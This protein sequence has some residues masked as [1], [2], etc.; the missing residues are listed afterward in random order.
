MI[1]IAQ[2]GEGNFLRAF[3]DLY[4]QT[5]NDEGGDYVV[6]VIKPT[7]RPLGAGF[8]SEGNSYNVVLRGIADGKECE[9]TYKVNCLDKVIL[10]HAEAERFYALAREPELKVIVSNTT[11]AGIVFNSDDTMGDLAASSFPA[12]LTL[13]L[14]ERYKSGLP[15]LYLL[16]AELIDNNAD[17]LKRCVEF[18]C[19]TWSLCDGFVSWLEGECFFCNTLVD[20]IVSGF[21][22]D[23][24][25]K[26]RLFNAIGCED[27]LL[28][29]GEPFGLWVIENKGDI[30][31][32]IKPGHHNIDIVL[33]DDIAYYKKRKV[34]V[35]NGS[36]TNIVP[37]ALMNGKTTVYDAVT[38]ETLRDFF[39][40]AL[41]EIIPYVSDDEAMTRKFADDVMERFMNPYLN[42]QLMSIALNSISKWRARILPTFK[43]YY[44]SK[45]K[46]PATLTTGFTYLLRLYESRKD[47]M[48]DTPE[49]LAFFDGGKVRLR[50]L[51]SN[52][53]IW[54]E[55]LTLY[56][57]F[58]D[59]VKSG[60]ERLRR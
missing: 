35:L 47:Q 26:S 43:D 55:D 56:D 23:E 42:H 20:R 60:L 14:Y 38:D 8:K 37:I 28:T 29:I 5:L 7:A 27:P 58:Y 57:G 39:Y 25:L 33:T 46:I 45:G 22:R 1:K 41:E 11:E 13:F 53:N 54:G 34:R 32:I 9:R 12:K 31:S 40:S 19:R 30:A 21:P 10:P 49:V 52:I 44:T 3:A 2:F 50:K 51:M 24:A 4:F 17:E 59:T 6:D 16:P 18:Y 48:T 15:G 36:H